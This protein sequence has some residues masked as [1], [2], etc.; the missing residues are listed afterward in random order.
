MIF[1][2]VRHGDPVYDPDSLTPLGHEQAKALSKRFALYGLDEIYA[3][4]STRAQMT[5]QPTCEVLGKEMTLLDWT[6]EG[7]AWHDFCVPK[8]DGKYCWS[9]QNAKYVEKFNSPEI[10]SLG[11][12]WHEHPDFKDLNFGAGVERIN[13]ETDAFF[14]QLGYKHDRVNRRY[15]IIKPNKKRVALFAHQG[16]GVAFLSSL[17][18]IPYPSFCT[19]FDFGHSSVTV[20]AFG[21]G[22]EEFAYP[23]V[24]QLSNDSHLYKEGKLTGY[25]NSIDI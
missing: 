23:K 9:F 19:H 20:I 13:R 14:L 22:E 12:Q 16:F 18:D 15:K 10:Y 8:E 5:A 17:L 4:T 24:F 11:Y 21:D 6:N 7:H 25:N 2:Y 1:Y 3:S